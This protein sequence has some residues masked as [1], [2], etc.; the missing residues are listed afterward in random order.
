MTDTTT[1]QP[2]RVRNEGTAGPYIILPFSQLEET[3]QLLDS[4]DVFY[5]VGE[6][7]ISIDG[8][9]EMVFINFGREGDPL[10]VQSILDS[11]P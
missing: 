4:R 11:V 9:P 8:A 2:L 5:W 7:A 1:K 6:N 3:K 10:S